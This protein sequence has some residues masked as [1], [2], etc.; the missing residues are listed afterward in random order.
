[1]GVEAFVSQRLARVHFMSTRLQSLALLLVAS[2]SAS[3][4]T[5]HSS[6]AEKCLGHTSLYSCSNIMMT[7]D[8]LCS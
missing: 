7:V 1:M 4:C 3:C 8:I 2:S 5:S 6:S